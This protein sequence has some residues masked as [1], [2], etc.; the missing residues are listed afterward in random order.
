MYLFNVTLQSAINP[1]E[2]FA[3]YLCCMAYDTH[4]FSFMAGAE[5]LHRMGYHLGMVNLSELQF[6]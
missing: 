4:D 5:F 2:D 6:S 3:D 1:T